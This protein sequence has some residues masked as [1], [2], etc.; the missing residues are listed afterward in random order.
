MLSNS[1]MK[2]RERIK[3]W[4]YA[5]SF[6]QFP[7]KHW[8]GQEKLEL[9]QNNDPNLRKGDQSQ[10]D[11]SGWSNHFKVANAHIILDKNEE[12]YGISLL[13]KDFW[14]LKMQRN[15]I[16]KIPCFKDIYGYFFR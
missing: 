9:I 12:N 6:L 11:K 7:N 2:K 15:N 10:S 13:V 4:F 16:R 8:L 5:S 1:I 3:G 14:L